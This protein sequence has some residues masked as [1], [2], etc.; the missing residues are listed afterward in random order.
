[1]KSTR[2]KVLQTLINKPRS[3]IVEIADSVGINAISVRHHLTSL[4]AAGLVSAEEE[5]HGVG[6]PR[7]VYFLTEKGLERF[8]TGYYR[9]TNLLLNQ[10]KNSISESEVKNLFKKMADSLSEQYLPV[11]ESLKLEDKLGLLKRVMAKEGFDLDWSSNLDTYQITEISCPF[12]QI[13][14]EHPEIC[15]FDKSLISNLLAVPEDEIKHLRKNNNQ[16]VFIIEKIK[17]HI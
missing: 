14:K 6:R 1:M 3:T 10:I 16:C 13:G 2:E 12:Y 7:L 15:L 17:D 5:R 4:Q 8:P 9:L 11:F